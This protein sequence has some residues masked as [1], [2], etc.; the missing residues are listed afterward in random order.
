MD[1]L[2]KSLERE[3]LV[4]SSLNRKQ[5]AGMWLDL[6]FISFIHT[7]LLFKYKV[8]MLLHRPIKG[9]EGSAW[10]PQFHATERP[11]A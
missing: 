9:L 10:G 11:L 4:A 1:E 8:E 6:M 7:W 3:F 2:G 5:Q